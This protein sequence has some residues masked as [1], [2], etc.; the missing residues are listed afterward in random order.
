METFMFQLGYAGQ[1]LLLYYNV[2]LIVVRLV[3]QETLVIHLYMDL[4]L[5]SKFNF[6][7]FIYYFIDLLNNLSW[8]CLGTLSFLMYKNLIN[9]N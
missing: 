6:L 5:Q 7:L 2:S 1:H 3:W 9:N 8:E 4:Y